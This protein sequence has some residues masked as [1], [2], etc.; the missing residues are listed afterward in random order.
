MGMKQVSEKKFLRELKPVEKSIRIQIE[1]YIEAH[2]SF[3]SQFEFGHDKKK[4]IRIYKIIL[5]NGSQRTWSL[6][7]RQH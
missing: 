2:G 5:K 1:N 4:H 3:I 7:R 6:T